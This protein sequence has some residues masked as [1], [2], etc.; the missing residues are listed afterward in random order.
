MFQTI[1]D[2]MIGDLVV[3]PEYE[4]IGHWID[5]VHCLTPLG[6]VVF[7]VAEVVR[8]DRKDGDYLGLLLANNRQ[9]SGVLV[10]AKITL[11]HAKIYRE[12][13][14]PDPAGLKATYTATY[15]QTSASGGESAV[16]SLCGECVDFASGKKRCT[17]GGAPI[18]ASAPSCGWFVKDYPAG[19]G[20]APAECAEPPDHV[21]HPEAVF[22]AKVQSTAKEIADL[23]VE[24]N[25]AYGNSFSKS[26]EIMKI[27]YHNGI[28]TEKMNDALAVV[29]VLD[30]LSRIATDRDAMGEN[31]WRDICGYALLVAAK[32]K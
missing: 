7:V 5:G 1:K 11:D 13:Q 31:P 22:M 18:L 4:E 28:P 12:V 6:G 29:R 8:K 30:K 20:D 3:F 27:L 10:S 2:V 9:K 19:A 16:K 26:G 17:T 15:T 14:A 23:V 24:K 25:Q 32:K 21:F